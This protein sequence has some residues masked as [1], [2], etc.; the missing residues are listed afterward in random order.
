MNAHEAS[1]PPACRRRGRRAQREPAAGLAMTRCSPRKASRTPEE[2]DRVV[3]VL[4]ASSVTAAF[5]RR[6]QQ[7]RARRP[8]RR[9]HARASSSTPCRSAA[10]SGRS[11]SIVLSAPM[12]SGE[13][14]IVKLAKNGVAGQGGRRRRRVRRVHAA[15][16]TMQEKQSE[17][18]QADARDRAGAGAAA[19]HRRSRTRPR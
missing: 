3:L 2:R 18:K 5:V 15:A 17:L 14:Q 6:P 13:L 9:R 1:S 11:K 16:A 7:R 8:D 19:D 4:S 10:T 12:Q